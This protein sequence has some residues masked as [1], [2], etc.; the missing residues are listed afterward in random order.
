[1]N[2][3]QIPL[4]ILLVVAIGA[5]PALSSATPD[6]TTPA[7][8]GANTN[9][10]ATEGG[11]NCADATPLFDFASSADASHATCRQYDLGDKGEQRWYLQ[12]VKSLHVPCKDAQG[13][14]CAIP[15]NDASFVRMCTATG[16][17]A[18]K[19]NGVTEP[20]GF[21]PKAGVEAPC[22]GVV[23]GAGNPTGPKGCAVC[24]EVKV[25]HP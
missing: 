14:P 8:P 25:P 6:P 19:V 11:T 1:M 17:P 4:R 15:F 2:R 13:A 20:A 18:R 22:A 24:G 16:H 12:V 10:N 9:S 21:A 7:G 23:T 3:I 5:A